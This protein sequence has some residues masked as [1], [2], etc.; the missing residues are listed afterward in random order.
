MMK[1]RA[2]KDPASSSDVDVDVDDPKGRGSKLVGLRVQFSAKATPAN[3]RDLIVRLGF[4]DGRKTSPPLPDNDASFVG[5]FA[6]LPSQVLTDSLYLVGEVHSLEGQSGIAHW[7]L[8]LFPS[9]SETPPAQLVADSAKIGGYP[10]VLRR[11]FDSW[12]GDR[13]VTARAEA[14]YHISTKRFCTFPSKFVHRAKTITV[15]TGDTEHALSPSI[16]MGIWEA[17]PPIGHVSQVAIMRVKGATSITAIGRIKLDLDPN[18]NLVE[19]VDK[20][21][22]IG[23]QMF[24]E[25]AT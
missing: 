4:Q 12:P 1:L 15:K 22:W 8:D 2:R 10:G 7:H 17:K 6:A 18:L 9:P 3:W 19:V 13:R 14:T 25:G 20:K 16:T 5:S 23:L 24:L 11:M 21:I